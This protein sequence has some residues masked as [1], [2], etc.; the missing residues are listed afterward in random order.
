MLTDTSKKN[1]LLQLQT[2][3]NQFLKKHWKQKSSFTLHFL[4]P[5]LTVV[6][7]K[8]GWYNA[9]WLPKEVKFSIA[10]DLNTYFLSQKWFW[11]LWLG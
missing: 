10:E 11:N 1:N 2:K 4:S 9:I 3:K 8:S 6:L 5:I 7:M